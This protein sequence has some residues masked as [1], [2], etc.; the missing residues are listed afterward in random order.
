MRM[1]GVVAQLGEHCSQCRGREFD[2]PPLH[3]L[4]PFITTS[5]EGF[6]RLFLVNRH[7][8][9]ILVNRR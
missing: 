4:K 8:V 2:P 1:F 5:Y 6:F 7:R 3:F 9:K